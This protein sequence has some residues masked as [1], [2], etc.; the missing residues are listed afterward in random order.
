MKY[1][2][3][4]TLSSI[5]LCASTVQ[6][7]MIDLSTWE[8]DGGGNWNVQQGNDSVLQTV[9]GNPTV[10]FEDGSNARGTAISGEITVRGTRDDD[11]IGFV[12]G[13]QDDELLSDSADYWLIDWKRNDQSTPDWG[14]STSGLSISHITGTNPTSSFWDHTGTNFTE[15]KRATNLGSTGWINDVTYS[16]D[17]IH[18]ASL[19]QVKVN[20]VI[21]LSL[22]NTEAG[23]T[24]FT[25]G[26]YGFY[27]FSQE[28]VLYAG[29]EER[30]A[31]VPE[32]TTLGL[33]ALGLAGLFTRKFKH[34]KK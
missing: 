1:I 9:N 30:I 4:I 26:A 5:L 3:N 29:I 20:D 18:T 7:A 31:S 25:D 14:F 19:I 10:F 17:I 24:E 33:F 28:N 6:A 32:T 11:F 34:N 27:N 15:K 8:N 12:L 23:V 21:E 2:T 22:T 16:F 13:Y